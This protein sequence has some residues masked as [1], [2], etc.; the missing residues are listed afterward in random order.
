[1]AYVDA[2]YE[3]VG[4]HVDTTGERV[5]RLDGDVYEVEEP[6]VVTASDSELVG[7]T[8]HRLVEVD[9]RWLIRESRWVEE[10]GDSTD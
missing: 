7:T 1:L 9:N 6:G 3:N 5:V 10:T 4:F 2:Y 8:T